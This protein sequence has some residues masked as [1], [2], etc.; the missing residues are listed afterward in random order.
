MAKK[1]GDPVALAYKKGRLD[2]LAKQALKVGG[3]HLITYYQDEIARLQTGLS[4]RDQKIAQREIELTVKDTEIGM[5]K[6]WQHRAVQA[7]A[8][9]AELQRTQQADAFEQEFWIEELVRYRN[10]VIEL[11]RE[12]AN[13]PQSKPLPAA[14]D[15]WSGRAPK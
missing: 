10:W 5:A 3:K 12:K 14:D 8:R 2:P 4:E 9:L 15:A 13:P 1:G 7:E 11:L 6:S